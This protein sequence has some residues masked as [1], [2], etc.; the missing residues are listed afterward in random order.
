MELKNIPNPASD[1]PIGISLGALHFGSDWHPTSPKT[2]ELKTRH[3]GH[4]TE[5]YHS[6][7]SNLMSIESFT[8][9]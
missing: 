8:E 7:H 4:R 1:S 3:D 2:F 5:Q 6:A 9:E